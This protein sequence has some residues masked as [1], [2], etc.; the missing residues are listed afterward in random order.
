MSYKNSVKLFSSNFNLVWKQLAFGCVCSVLV[1][2][3]SLLLALPTI[4]LLQTENWF[5]T[6]NNLFKVVYTTPVEINAT[7]KDIIL[8]LANILSANFGSYW[9]SYIGFCLSAIILPMFLAGISRYTL[10]V[11]TNNKISSLANVG[12]TN[13]LITNL[14]KASI[15][16]LIKLLIDLAFSIVIVL[17]FCLYLALAKG[18][19]LTVLLVV[20]FLTIT[21]VLL[22]LKLVLTSSFAPLMVEEKLPVLKAFRKGVKINFSNFGRTLSNAIILILTILFVNVFLGV[23]TIGVGLFITLPATAVILSIFMVINYYTI[24]GRRYYLTES[25]IVEPKTTTE[26]KNLENKGNRDDGDNTNTNN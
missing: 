8:S 15:Y 23:F 11:L 14:G 12:Y 16:S 17:L 24:T 13:T 7:F 25:L 9:F 20:I 1:A 19:L 3:L 4:R 10:C 6:C 26:T 18:V 21:V 5:E 2:L 22:S